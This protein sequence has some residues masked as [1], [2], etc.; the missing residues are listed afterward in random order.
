MMISNTVVFLSFAGIMLSGFVFILYGLA[1]RNK[2]NASIDYFLLSDKKMSGKAFA[3][4]FYATTVS[5][6]DGIIF[7][8]SAH[9]EY[10]WLMGLAVVFYTAAQLY[11]LNIVKKLK[12]DFNKIRT[13]SDLW[14][15]I[16]PS[17]KIARII[18]G[19][20]FACSLLWLF[21]ELYIGSVILSVLLPDTDIYKA[22]S[23][24]VL[25]ALVVTYV[26]FGG[27]KAIVKTDKW[28]VSLLLISVLVLIGFVAYVPSIGEAKNTSIFNKCFGYTES[29]FSLYIFLFWVCSI[30]ILFCF[31]NI[32]TWQRMSAVVSIN[33]GIKG[34]VKGLWKFALIFLGPMMCI[35]ILGAKGYS[36]SDMPSF[37]SIIY[38]E[39]GNLSFIVFP[40]IVVGFSAALFSTADTFLIGAA[41]TLCD[42]NT[43]LNKIEA[44]PEDKRHAT[45]RKYISIFTVLIVCCLSILYYIQ[46]QDISKYIM[47]IIYAHWGLLFGLSVLPMY[48]FFRM[49]KNLPPMQASRAS[50]KVL[51]LGIILC[52]CV[53]VTGSLYEMSTGMMIY[54]QISNLLAVVV[55]AVSLGLSIK[56]DNKKRD[57]LVSAYS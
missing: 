48:A 28:Q 23:F 4:T 56:I 57:I 10:G 49:L 26:N 13:V 14:Y 21:L 7:F 35:I 52:G 19:C 41:Y 24:F 31:T 38:K 44:I 8:I 25:G 47:P 32:H 20:I 17:K 33:E 40:V 22:G 16:Y 45:V 2:S 29:G 5:L 15:S 34:I 27:Y 3:N 42:K 53:L 46:G 39:S 18:S 36:F 43:L 1:S 50:E 54:S 51:L 37:L 55:I 12:I 11:M 6:A 9:H 30:N